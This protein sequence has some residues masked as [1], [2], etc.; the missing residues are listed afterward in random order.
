ME[1]WPG[2]PHFV[3]NR[4]SARLRK[5]GGPRTASVDDR[6]RPTGMTGVYISEYVIL[7]EASFF[8]M[9]IT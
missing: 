8:Q 5:R 4:S 7:P 6:C 1:T 3:R 9:Y 2:P